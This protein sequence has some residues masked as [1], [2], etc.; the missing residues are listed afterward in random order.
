M[1]KKVECAGDAE[2]VGAEDLGISE[3]NPIADDFD[4][5]ELASE[6][7]GQ[8][9]KPQSLGLN[10]G[11]GKP[12][13]TSRFRTH[14]DPRYW[15]VAYSIEIEVPGEFEKIS[16]IVAPSFVHMFQGDARRR[17]FAFY[18][19]ADGNL[20]FWPYAADDVGEPDGDHA[21][22][23]YNVCLHARDQ[24]VTTKWQKGEGYR[25][26][27]AEVGG[28]PQWPDK[29]PLELLKIAH[30]GRLVANEDHPRLR[31]YLARKPL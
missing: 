15:P 24:W 14:S 27:A 9:L 12:T 28:E 5:S 4:M 3:G 11:V 22:S 26:Y 17:R 20:R 13:K 30:K 23:V 8:L 16:L 1:V 18:Y 10:V 25:A 7:T 2:A 6:G 31:E 29:P 19:T 21:V